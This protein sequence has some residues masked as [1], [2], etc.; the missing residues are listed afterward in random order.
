[1]K[2]LE[3]IQKELDQAKVEGEKVAK[4]NKAAGV[5]LRKHLQ[6]IKNL[7]QEGRKAVVAAKD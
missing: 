6:T 4:G 1:M 5:R 7:C 3:L 2:E